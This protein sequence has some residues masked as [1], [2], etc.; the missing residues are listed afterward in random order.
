MEVNLE[1]LVK[2]LKGSSEAKADNG[3]RSTRQAEQAAS[4]MGRRGKARD[5]G[6]KS[7]T[8]DVEERKKSISLPRPLKATPMDSDMVRSNPRAK[9]PKRDRPVANSP[10]PK[11]TPIKQTD[12]SMAGLT[13]LQKGMRQ[14][15]D[16]ARFRQVPYSL[17][18][19]PMLTT[20]RLINETLYKTDSR[21]AHQMM[22]SDPK[23]YEDVS[24]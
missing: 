8:D 15:L 14:S 21:Q 10:P 3:N 24:P 22:L 19:I 12:G 23:V 13:S 17:D 6:N 18:L 16:G 9:K 1:K 4:P 2:R 7:K 5:R 20:S 11:T